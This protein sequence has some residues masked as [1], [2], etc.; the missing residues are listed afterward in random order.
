MTGSTTRGDLVRS[1]VLGSLGTR[2]PLSRAALSRALG[3]SPATV[4][5]A[6]RE[7][8]G[9]G[10]IVELDSV[11]SDGGRPARLLGLAHEGGGAL[12]VK[13]T[14]DHI[15]VVDVGL[16][17]TIRSS[18]QHPFDPGAPDALDRLGAMLADVIADRAGR[19]LLGV[20][21]GVPG[22]ANSQEA[23]VVNAP[24]LDWV[25]TRLGPA[26]RA[27]LDVPVLVENDVNTLAVAESLYGTGRDL[28]SYLVVTIGRGIG[29]GIVVDG[30]VYRGSGGGAGEIGHIP[31]TV[32][33]PVCG[34]GGRGCLE[35]HVGDA[36]LVRRARESG[37]IGDADGSDALLRAAQRGD[38]SA[39]AIYHDAGTVLGRA[40][41][42]V[43]HTVDP[44]MILLLGEGIDAWP[45]WRTGF[46]PSFR[47]HLMPARRGLTVQVEPW[48]EDRWALGA[49]ALVLASPFDATG[50]SG[51]QG[52]QVRERLGSANLDVT[53]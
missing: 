26:L 32:D 48:A 10:L 33:G 44:E 1:A 30:T 8:L 52:R 13:V 35:A 11:P 37:V 40:L 45:F 51:E 41:A 43:V 7:L 31:V 38:V 15:A 22:A 23:G 42:G 53:G 2:G 25:E 39:A 24:T 34:C 21:I 46:E 18:E 14:A 19:P 3:V 36:A 16:D 28:D 27:A 4:T 5:Q 49:A 9:R 50:A 20:G 12:G 17:G 29:C 6:T 47:G